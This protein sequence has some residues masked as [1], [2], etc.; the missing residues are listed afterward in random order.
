MKPTLLALIT[1]ALT[2]TAHAQQAT[3]VLGR[4]G[5]EEITVGEIRTALKELGVKPG[6]IGSNDP[7]VL[8]QVVRSLLVQ[9]ILLQEAIAKG[10]DKDADVLAKLE[11]VRESTITES[12]LQSIAAPPATYPSEAELKSAYE[13]NSAALL[14]PRSYRLAQV[15]IAAPREGADAAEEQKA[16]AKI[17]EVAQ[18]LAAADA[19]FAAIASAHSEETESAGRGGEIGWVLETQIQPEIRAELPDLKLGALSKPIRLNDGWHIVK[20]LDIREPFTP[21]LE[22]VRAQLTQRLRTEKTKANSEAYL[23]QLL[24][25]NPLAINELAL[26]QVLATEDK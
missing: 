17:K 9:R 11:R 19:D 14:V 12:Y 24:K 5:K 8:N 2:S 23:T 26:N 7:A 1:L 22:Q 10:W 6:A 18:K 25:E 21:T 3:D 16:V 4:I 20:V 15:F 13:D